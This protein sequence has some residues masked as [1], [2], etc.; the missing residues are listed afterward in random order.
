MEGVC[1]KLVG[2]WLTGCNPIGALGYGCKNRKNTIE[3]A[4]VITVNT[5]SGMDAKIGKTTRL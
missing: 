3:L 4:F 5:Y 2:V 1:V